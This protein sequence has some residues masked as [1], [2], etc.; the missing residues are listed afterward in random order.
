MGNPSVSNVVSAGLPPCHSGNIKVLSIGKG[1][2]YAGGQSKGIDPTG[3]A[4]IDLVGDHKTGVQALNDSASK[5]FA[6]TIAAGDIAVKKILPLLSF[7]MPDFSV[8][9]YKADVWEA[10]ADEINTLA[11]DGTKVLAA[12]Q[13]G[14]G[15]TGI[16]VSIVCALLCPSVHDEPVQ[17]IRKIYCEKAVE[18]RA[19]HEYVHEILGLPVPPQLDYPHEHYATYSYGSWGGHAT[20]TTGSPSKPKVWNVPWM[21]D[22][23]SELVRLGVE[24]RDSGKLL[25]DVGDKSGIRW[26]EPT[27]Y[28]KD[29][30]LVLFGDF[31]PVPINMLYTDGSTPSPKSDDSK[32]EKWEDVLVADLDGVDADWKYVGLKKDTIAVN[33]GD[34]DPEYVEVTFY[35]PDTSI[36]F[37]TR[38]GKNVQLALSSVACFAPDDADVPWKEEGDGFSVLGILLNTATKHVV[39]GDKVFVWLDDTKAEA[40]DYRDGM[41]VLRMPDTTRIEISPYELEADK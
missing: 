40:M 32:I 24:F 9:K 25:V 8:P 31:A 3:F 35:N 14:H 11:S 12:C 10:V 30:G 18:T 7:P 2:L 4:F 20:H 6:Q 39:E 15:R 27:G 28:D 23:V 41:L 1:G 5:A 16:F 36:L 29:K 13:G 17:Y 34:D 37:C 38:D 19:Q 26:A 21:D 33:I 22:L